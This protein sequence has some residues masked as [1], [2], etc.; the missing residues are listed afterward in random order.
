MRSH[1][2][3]DACPLWIVSSFLEQSPAMVRSDRLMDELGADSFDMGELQALVEE[4]FGIQVPRQLPT[5]IT[6][7]EL[8]TLVLRSG[9]ALRC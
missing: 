1:R 3:T 7:D 4:A 6:C 9:A 8:L 2:Y 5:Y